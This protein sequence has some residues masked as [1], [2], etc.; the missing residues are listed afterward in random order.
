MKHLPYL[1]IEKEADAFAR[2]Y[3]SAGTIP[4][5][6]DDIIELDLR[7]RVEAH[8]GLFKNLS[9]DAFLSRDFTE[10]H[11]DEENY[12]G[13]TNRSRFTIAHEIGHYV[14]HREYAQ[15]SKSIADWKVFILGAGDERDIAESQANNFAGCLLM[16]RE[17]AIEQFET[18]KKRATERF[19]Q[20]GLSTPNDSMLIDYASNELAKFFDVSDQVAQIRTTRILK[21]SK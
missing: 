8:K 6:V 12:L 10:I 18:H 16:P 9:I 13:Q 21:Y 5:P 2:Q 14:L 19:R 17:L 1:E 3:N 11:I 4:V 7:L 20:A 15:S